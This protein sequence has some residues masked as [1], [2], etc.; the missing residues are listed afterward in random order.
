MFAAGG[1]LAYGLVAPEIPFAD[2]PV[3]LIRDLRVDDIVKVHGRIDC[4]C[5]KAI[6]R[7]ENPVGAT[8][9]NWNATYEWFSVNDPSGLIFIETATVTRLTPGPSGGDWLKGDLVTVYGSVF[10]QGMG[11]LLMRG[12]MI[13]KAPDDTPAKYAFWMLV[14]GALGILSIGY[15]FTDRLFFGGPPE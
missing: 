9:R 7:E 3:K 2:A 14:S 13:A 1:L 11:N 15:V 10:D 5:A 6:D 4:D 8:G 12:Q